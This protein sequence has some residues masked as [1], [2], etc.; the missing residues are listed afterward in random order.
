MGKRVIRLTE[1]DIEKIVKKVIK[2][3]TE[4]VLVNKLNDKIKSV[5]VKNQNEI[6]NG[7][8]LV[9]SK[10]DNNFIIN[11]S[12]I[13]LKLYL[14]ET[15]KK[16]GGYLPN[17]VLNEK[18]YIDTPSIPL[19][20]FY[21][22]IW[23][24]DDDLKTYYEENPYIKNQMD[25]LLIPLTIKFLT[26]EGLKI[27]VFDPN[28]KLNI[29]IKKYL[30]NHSN[31][32]IGGLGDFYDNNLAYFQ[33]DNVNYE[34]TASNLEVK[35]GEV[36]IL[37]P[38][39]DPSEPE[40]PGFAT[41]TIKLDLID[42]FEYDSIKMKDPL[43]Y[44]EILNKFNNELAEGLRRT[45]KFKEFLKTQN[46]VVNGYASQDDNPNEKIQGKFS[47]CREYGDGSRGQYNLCL[48]EARAKKVAE[49]LQKI[50]N[51]LNIDVDIKSE[52][53]GETYE[54][55]GDGWD[56]GKDSQEDLAKNRRVTF[57]IPEYK[58]T[59]RN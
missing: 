9:A 34:I 15:N 29:R 8:K 10:P 22:D 46:L 39:V 55:G 49:D 38:Q 42:V 40:N 52:G 48:S 25:K 4:E 57:N 2:E 1:A 44:Q 36:N 51:S 30:K 43:G 6:F 47:G 33:L 58:E 45:V 18:G 32:N 24:K 31:G 54:F 14:D 21:D 7:V 16:Y 19:S 27:N 23:E 35:L 11:I 41:E 12:N 37:P 3:Q 13:S 17:W 56:N 50:F 26:T 59:I 28:T 20:N 53:H 5:M